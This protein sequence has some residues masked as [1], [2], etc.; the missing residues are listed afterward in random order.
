MVVLGSAC[1]AASCTSRSVGQEDRAV[2]ALADSQIDGPR[3]P[4]RQRDRHYLGALAGDDQRAVAA[5]DARR[6][7]AGTGGLRHPAAR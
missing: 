6:P 5:L 7:D 4:R 1:E 2:G 3:G